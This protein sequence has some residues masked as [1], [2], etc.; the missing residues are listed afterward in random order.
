MCCCRCWCCSVPVLLQQQL[1]V[2]AVMCLM[3]KT[4]AGSFDLIPSRVFFFVIQTRYIFR[5]IYLGSTVAFTDSVCLYYIFGSYGHARSQGGH[6][7]C[8]VFSSLFCFVSSRVVS[9][10][11]TSTAGPD[12]P[13]I[14]LLYDVIYTWHVFIHRVF[15]P[16]FLMLWIGVVA[17]AAAAFRLRM[18]GESCC[19][20]IKSDSVQCFIYLH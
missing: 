9:Q 19:W 20:F 10:P 1:L 11:S 3:E 18:D 12:I 2:F 14:I 5:C 8:A 16:L 17:A 15:L 7:W 6:Q 4:V 13:V